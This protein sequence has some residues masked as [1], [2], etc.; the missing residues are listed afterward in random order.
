MK[1]TDHRH[2][3]LLSTA[4]LAVLLTAGLLLPV[5]AQNSAPPASGITT[6][7][8]TNGPGSTLSMQPRPAV[9]H[10][11]RI[12]YGL[13]LMARFDLLPLLRDTYCVQDSSY[14]R[15][16][17]NG[18]SGNFLRVEGRKAVLADIRGP[19]C[20]YRFW[21]ANATGQ[22]RIFLDGET[23][24]RIDCPMQDFFLGKIAPLVQPIVG[25]RSG[26]WYS[27]FPMP[28]AKSCRIEVTD[29]GGLYY[30]VQYQLY[31]DKTKIRTFT[32]MLTPTEQS[33]LDVIVTQWKS[34]GQPP[35]SPSSH[36][37]TLIQT[38]MTALG[39]GETRTIATVKGPGEITELH[40]GFADQNRFTLRQ[41]LLRVYWDGAAKPAIEAP[42]GDFFGVGFGNNTVAA[43]PTAL[44]TDGGTCWWRM[45]FHSSA[46]F[47][48]VNTSKV[49]LPLVNYKITSIL[50]KIAADAGWFHAQ[51]HRQTTVAGEHFR[52]LHAIG[53]GHYVG[54]HT[55]MQGD[56]GIWFLEGDEKIYAD[57]ETFPSIYGTGTE[58]FYTG[59]WYFDEGPFGLA[60]H[61]CTVKSDELSRVS[62][63]RFQIQDCVPFQKELIVD[64]EH[65]GTNDYPGADYS[66]VAY[67]YQDAPNHDWSPI[68]PA[69]LTPA[70]YRN[71][72]VQE[73]ESLTWTGDGKVTFLSDS[74]LP[75]EASGGRVAA[76]GAGKTTV[77]FMVPTDDVYRL[78]AAQVV[79]SDS[80]AALAWELQPANGRSIMGIWDAPHDTDK[81]QRWQSATA[82]LRLPQGVNRLTLQV[83]G[84]KTANI[85]FLRLL[86]SR[87]EPKAIE[88]E[89]LLSKI[90]A[91][92][93]GLLERVDGD[94]TW[95]GWSAVRWRTQSGGTLRVPLD[96]PADGD[97]EILLAASSTAKSTGLRAAIDNGS[98][99]MSAPEN[100]AELKTELET[101]IARVT[102]GR[103]TGLKQGTCMLVLTAEKQDSEK[104]TAFPIMLDYF[105]LRRSRYPNS[106]E[107]ESLRILQAKDG[108][109]E[110]QAMGSA[111][112]FWS[113]DAQFWFRA[114]KVGAEATLE[115]P[116]QIAGR[117][118]IAAYYTTARDYGTVQAFLDGA[119]IGTPTDCWT[120]DVLAK[121]KTELGTIILT[122]GNHRLTFRAVGKNPQSIGYFIGVDALTLDPI[123]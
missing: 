112:S 56:R 122:A 94:E 76:V 59:G 121:G 43:L 106:V 46:R 33:A 74:E 31:P 69:Q 64:I 63:Y 40:I 5:L 54:E 2:W 61:G 84:G 108:A 115:L 52:I 62:A 60:Y 70:I 100:A 72:G 89:T 51:W 111:S 9:P 37:K 68:D 85:D 117:Y 67:W 21:S 4:T 18:D 91:E 80:P 77:S 120:P 50:K 103:Y 11:P 113:N 28:F 35:I 102:L 81:L 55:D 95:S 23:D 32:T 79:S 119:A 101:S 19:G 75:A 34:L 83:P 14:D 105:L 13:E 6:P 25:H 3:H 123:R 39:P 58:D 45:P 97:Y 114:E 16:G 26:G 47:E 53:R 44:N 12:P 86:P 78:E 90:K 57:G 66:C 65:G 49:P 27:F 116:I 107:A 104:E 17:G 93:G 92:Q 42:V 82:P 30:H 7:A 20:I 24:P 10:T 73:A 118:K 87:R 41:T 1:T 8:F 98:G 109:A 29:P 15:S 36:E 71:A 96:I 48:L 99:V 88:A 110:T 22:L 38:A